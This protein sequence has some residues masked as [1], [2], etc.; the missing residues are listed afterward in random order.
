MSTTY[1]ACFCNKLWF[2][3]IKFKCEEELSELDLNELLILK[4]IFKRK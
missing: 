4:T 2:I 1:E 3:G